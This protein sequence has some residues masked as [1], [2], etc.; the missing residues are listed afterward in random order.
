MTKTL[1]VG[2]GL[3][4]AV[5]AYLLTKPGQLRNLELCVWDKARGCGGRMSTSRLTSNSNATCSADLGAQYITATEDYAKIHSDYYND[6]LANKLLDPLKLPIEG[7]KTP[8]DGSMN[9]VCPQGSSSLVKHFF[10]EAAAQ[11][12]F[13]KKVSKI[14]N[15]SKQWTVMAE[16]GETESFDAI[17]LTMPVPQILELLSN[18]S[19]LEYGE[20]DSG[21]KSIL[22]QLKEVKY[23]SRYAIALLYECE[24]ESDI[25]IVKNNIRLENGAC[26]KYITGDSVFRYVSFDNYKRA[27]NPN[28]RT[29]V[30]VPLSVVFH[31][32]IPFGIENIEKTPDEVQPILLDRIE[33]LFPSWPKP[34]V[35]KCQKWRYSQV[36][37]SYPG[38]P[39]CVEILSS[40]LLL[41]GGDGFMH[42]NFDG[43]IQSAEAIVKTFM[44][45]TNK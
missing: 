34:T 41:A 14:E 18:S 4:S 27:N 26:A 45:K 23:S 16:D 43:C 20:N 44:D 1:L 10:K 19:Q 28:C 21:Q 42:S 33:K 15:N 13:G 12:K 9:Y 31:T 29:S 17:I 32:S 37:Q 5:T 25:E 39:G 35:V 38:N 11:V 40:P 24:S 36:Q 6:L 22:S 7:H 8:V 3:T 2:G 30:M